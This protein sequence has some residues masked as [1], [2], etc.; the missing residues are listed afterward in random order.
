MTIQGNG[1]M[2]GFY[3]SFRKNYKGIILILLSSVLVS[4]GQL[5]WKLSGGTE[6]GWLYAGFV[7]YGIG[8]VCMLVAFRFGSFSVLH[9]MLCTSYVLSLL[10]GSFVLYENIGW[11][12]IGGIFFIMAGVVLIGGG[13]PDKSA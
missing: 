6:P 4:L 1:T 11:L 3:E 2:N 7:F 9:P 12:K 10:L 13:D 5:F 8:A